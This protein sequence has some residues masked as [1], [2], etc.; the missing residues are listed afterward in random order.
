MLQL[1]G[2]GEIQML[3]ERAV[4]GGS[5]AISAAVSRVDDD[6]QAVLIICADGNG[7]GR[8]KGPPKPKRHHN[9]EHR[10]KGEAKKKGHRL[11]ERRIQVKIHR[12]FCLF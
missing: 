3:F 7:F 12:R 1:F 4:S 10:K 8:K 2:N 11:S 9:E 6:R 5:T